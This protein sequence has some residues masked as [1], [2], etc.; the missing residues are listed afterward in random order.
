MPTT[1]SCCC[2]QRSGSALLISHSRGTTITKAPSSLRPPIRGRSRVSASTACGPG[3]GGRKPRFRRTGP[4]VSPPLAQFLGQVDASHHGD[5]VAFVEVSRHEG[6]VVGRSVLLNPHRPAYLS[7]KVP[8]CTP[9]R[10]WKT[11]CMWLFQSRRASLSS[12]AVR[13]K[14]CLDVRPASR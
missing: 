14:G 10:S 11:S 12:A 4:F 13:V 5:I 9:A 3:P 2:A 7:P 8:L 6:T 1:S